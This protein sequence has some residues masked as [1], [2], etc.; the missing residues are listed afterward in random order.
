MAPFMLL[1]HL[2]RHCFLG[3]VFVCVALAS[4]MAW[5][6]TP[7]SASDHVRLQLKWLHQFQFAGYYAAVEKGYYRDAGIDV[8]LVEATP[9]TDVIKEVTDGRSHYGVGTSE[10]LL[11]R[12]K[13]APV[14]ALAVIY[15]HSPFMLLSLKSDAIRDVHDL[16]G[17]PIML[18]KQSADIMAYFQNEGIDASKLAIVPH[19]FNTQDLIAGKVA[20]MTAYST[21]EPYLLRTQGL[22]SMEFSPRSGGVDFYGDTLFTSDKELHD[23]P[24]RVKAFRA[25]SLKGWAYAMDHPDEIVDLILQKYSQKRSRDRL[26]FEAIETNRLMHPELIE[27]GH[28]NPGRWK[29]IEQVYRDTG[30]MTGSVDLDAFL[31]KEKTGLDLHQIYWIMTVLGGV[32]TAALLWLFPL[33]RLNQKLRREILL[34]SRTEQQLRRSEKQ[35]RD[36]IQAAPFPILIAELKTLRVLFANQRAMELLELTSLPDPSKPAGP[37]DPHHFYAYSEDRDRILSGVASGHTLADEEIACLTGKGRLIWA[38][39]SAGG[40]EFDGRPSVLISLNEITHRHQRELHLTQARDAAQ[41]DSASKDRALSL[42]SQEVKAPLTGLVGLVR[43]VLQSTLPKTVRDNLVLVEEAAE[44]LVHLVSDLLDWTKADNE[45]IDLVPHPIDLRT[46]TSELCS[47]FRPA[48]E[49][50]G[51]RLNQTVDE[52][53]PVSVRVDPLHLRQIL[54]NLLNNA[55]KFTEKGEIS[56]S[57][58]LGQTS[59]PGKCQ[60]RF[61]IQDTGIG[62]SEAARENLFTAPDGTV[63]GSRP[64]LALSRDLARGMGGDLLLQTRQNGGE[65]CL[66]LVVL[67]A[68]TD[69]STSTATARPAVA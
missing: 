20:A 50:K 19:T 46:F 7:A 1:R 25:A 8:D 41:S 62:I 13:G 65:G 12:S 51:I 38:L 61:E 15:Q 6:D 57:L 23:H 48:A 67:L 24:D 59:E 14:V 47:L 35:Y 16:V 29:D 9:E 11:A 53:V 45:K 10:L 40:T 21:D 2:V 43:L 66:F 34:R 31:Y 32:T 27:I 17:K 56:V 64:G 58:R 42:M 5:A 52:S 55:V 33:L 30:M 60:I 4:T 37:D 39:V 18:E 69:L 22:D 44:S 54:T 36:L 68:D 63:K 26:V 49:A 28:I 3:G